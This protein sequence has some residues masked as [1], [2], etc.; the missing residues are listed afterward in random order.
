MS[1]PDH[2]LRD[3]RDGSTEALGRVLERC[4]AFL[5][6]IAEQEMGAD[7]RAK[8][9]ASDLVQDTFLEAQRDFPHF[10]GRSEAELLAWL[11]RMLLNN[12]SNFIRQY[13]GT[14]KRRVDREEA[15]DQRPLSKSTPRELADSMRTPSGVLMEQEQADQLAQAMAKL[16]PQYQKVLTLRYQQEC[17]FEEIGRELGMTFSAAR[18]LWLRAVFQLQQELSS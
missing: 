12:L 1:A 5:L 17:T 8:G 14:E 13:R 6:R 16:T 7:L 18:K 4:R 9:G 10:A 2:D 3:A 15:I 11:R